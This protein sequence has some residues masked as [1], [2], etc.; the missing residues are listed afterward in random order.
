MCIDTGKFE[1]PVLATVT[2]LGID[3]HLQFAALVGMALQERRGHDQIPLRRELALEFQ[4]QTHHG[5]SAFHID[6]SKR[7][8]G[9][10]DPKRGLQHPRWGHS[11]LL[12]DRLLPQERVM[13]E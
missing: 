9:T 6:Y 3:N 12:K 13:D 4:R 5:T 1:Y 7:K 2:A 11:T 8:A 10:A